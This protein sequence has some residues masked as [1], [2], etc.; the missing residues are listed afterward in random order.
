MAAIKEL[1]NDRKKWRARV[2]ELEKFCA[3]DVREFVRDNKE[4][5]FKYLSKNTYSVNVDDWNHEEQL[6][7]S[8][9]YQGKEGLI[10]NG[11]KRQKKNLYTTYQ[12]LE[13]I[14]CSLDVIYFTKKYVKI[15]SLDDGIIPFSLYDYQEDLLDLYQNNRFIISMQA[16]QTG[17]TATTAAFLCWFSIFHQAKTSAVLAQKA[18][19]AQEILE[20]VQMAYEL[21]PCFLQDGVKTYNKRSMKLS[22]DSRIFSA[23]SASSAVRGK[24]IALL[25]VDEAAFI[26]N[27]M[28][29]YES[30]YPTISSGKESRV[31]I[32]STPNGTR[33]MFYKLWKES[34]AGINSYVRKLVTWDQVPNRDEE[35][36]QETIN[37]SSE[38]QF[39]QEHECVT[40]DTL[41]QLK[42]EHIE[43]EIAVSDLYDLVSHCSNS[44]DDKYI[45][46]ETISELCMNRKGVV[47]KITRIDFLEYIGTTVNMRR[48]LY[49]HKKSARFKEGILGYEILFEGD[50]Y[51]CLQK[52]AEF[53]QEHRTFECGLNMA[54]RGQGKNETTKFNTLGLKHSE[55]TRKKIGEASKRKTPRRGWKHTEEYKKRM[56]K[57]RKGNPNIKGSKI[58]INQAKKIITDYESYQIDI[59]DAMPYLKLRLQKEIELHGYNNQK[60]VMKNGKELTRFALYSILKGIEY[61]VTTNAIKSVLKG[62]RVIL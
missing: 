42:D 30:T 36:K 58:S 23:S 13:W 46:S 41:V 22:N 62:R 25:Y 43:V 2:A 9:W 33:G 54:E 51:E 14:K 26:P 4:L 47:Y 12:K 10:R 29:F 37:N 34:E 18:D 61:G 60:L 20:R 5:V 3:F 45:Q 1:I 11:T 50:Y 52:E 19:Q 35:W 24:S 17:K 21:L 38:E 44:A 15:I 53:I 16:R 32:T 27:D 6:N 56:S 48:R 40:G 55:E 31:I 39:R 57:M 8:W 28:S 49:E 7:E 59:N